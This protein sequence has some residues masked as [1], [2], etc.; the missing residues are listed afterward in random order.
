M[1]FALGSA[2]TGLGGALVA[3]FVSAYPSMGLSFV[4]PSFLTILAGTPGSLPG[5]IAS[6]SL[7]GTVN[8]V[9]S[10]LADP[11]LGSIVFVLLSVLVVTFRRSQ[12]A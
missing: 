9:V 11:V 6:S 10:Y 12:L 3:P 2:I 8:S 4:S 5:L 7:L 1:A